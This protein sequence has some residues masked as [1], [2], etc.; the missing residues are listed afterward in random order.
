M[1]A[2]VCSGELGTWRRGMRA[3]LAQRL[4]GPL[5]ALPLQEVPI[6]NIPLTAFLPTRQCGVPFTPCPVA[7]CALLLDYP[8]ALDTRAGTHTAAGADA[9]AA[10]ASYS[11]SETA[12][13]AAARALFDEP[14][15][16][17]TANIP[18]LLWQATASAAPAC[19]PLHP[20][21]RVA[22]SVPA[23]LV[24][25][26]PLASVSSTGA[27]AGAAWEQRCGAVAAAAR[28]SMWRRGLLRGGGAA[29]GSRDLPTW[30]RFD[31]PERPTEVTL[32]TGTL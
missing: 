15:Q 31:V 32:P 7:L 30:F 10:G 5:C 18:L 8:I 26:S 23:H 19:P 28:I 25:L 17:T 24:D 20:P 9:A 27:D 22:F 11:Y 6:L 14:V 29:L 21:L 16:T 12:A 1:G 13:M 4:W 2:S 3:F